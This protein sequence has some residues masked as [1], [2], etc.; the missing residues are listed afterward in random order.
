GAA[1]SAGGDG[2]PVRRRTRSRD[3]R[4]ELASAT[5]V[6]GA[7]V[8]AE[9][10][11]ERLGLDQALRLHGLE[12]VAPLPPAPTLLRDLL[13]RHRR[14]GAGGRVLGLEPRPR[15]TLVARGDGVARH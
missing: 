5:R 13:E 3:R 15:D 2:A 6:T 12:D 7:V 9:D 11:T 10:L 8:A 4:D 14:G 1:G